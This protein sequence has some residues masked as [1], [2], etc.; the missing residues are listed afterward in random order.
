MSSTWTKIL[1]PSGWRAKILLVVIL[2]IFLSLDYWEVVQPIKTFLE[3]DVMAFSIGEFR[4]TAYLVIK[5]SLLV[6][7]LFWVTGII[8]EFG[9]NRIK[10]INSLRASNKAL[11]VK[12][13]QIA[14]Y[15]FAAIF[16][17]DVLGIDLTN[18]AIFSGAVGIGIGFGLQKITSNFISGL[19]LL[20]EKSV[21]EEDL[22]EMP[23]GTFGFVRHTG[24][25]YTL[26]EEFDGKEVMVPNEDFITSKVTNW[27]FTNT[28]GRVEIHVGVS[29]DCDIENARELILQAASEHPRCSHD[30][31]PQCFL[32]EFGDSS[33][34]FLL[35]FWV[36]DVNMGRFE[37]HSD[38]MR[39][40]W[41]KFKEHDIVIPY[42]QRD[43]HIK[44]QET[45]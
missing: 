43:I 28:R 21:E 12:A 34:N 14:V 35:Y 37:P 29:Y 38:V 23:D 2:A 25:R 22:V 15:F 7:L 45:P 41:R 5:G 9:E 30:P 17:L 42:P 36:D 4:V 13:F 33:V 3:S 40:I 18:M 6:F 31:A 20:F 16:F 39:T 11:I 19:I 44:S 26:I 32:R 10:K 27:T 1:K 24:A 8:S